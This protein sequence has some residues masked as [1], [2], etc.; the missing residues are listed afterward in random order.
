MSNMQDMFHDVVTDWRASESR[1]FATGGAEQTRR[2]CRLFCA[3]K[4]T[5]SRYDK[6]TNSNH[7]DIQIEVYD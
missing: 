7:L 1:S 6:C 4:F 5:V 2:P 3:D